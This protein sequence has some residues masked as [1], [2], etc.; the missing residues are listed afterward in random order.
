MRRAVA[1]VRQLCWIVFGAFVLA[2]AYYHINAQNH[3]S[4]GGFVGLALL[5]KYAFDLS[6]AIMTLALDIPLFLVAF[7]V[8]GRQFLANTMI[9]SFAFSGFYDLFERFSPLHIDLSGFMPLAALLSGLL[10]G[11]GAGIVLRYGGATGGDDILAVLLSRHTGLSI[12]T[13][14]L[15]LDAL[16]L[17]LSLLYL[18]LRE[19]LYTI[20]AV[21]IA[22]RVINWTAA[23]GGR[24]ND[25]AETESIP[26]SL[27]LPHH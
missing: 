23:A 3:L 4:E 14:F 12:G 24:A 7:H 18:P 11:W 15:L 13:V 27:T 2:F 20:L 5:A 17:S 6:P 25:R 22:S 26:R 10:T 19:T 1:Y 8:K 16:V 21:A 9:A